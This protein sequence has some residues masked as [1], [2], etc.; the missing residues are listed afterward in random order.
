VLVVVVLPAVLVGLAVAT[1][2]ALSAL[3]EFAHIDYVRRVSDF[4]VPRVGDKIEPETA[5]EAACRKIG[6]RRPAPCGEPVDLDRFDALGYQYEAQQPPLYYAVVAAVRPLVQVGPI[7]SFV[8]AARL[9]GILW[10]VAGLATLWLACRR[11]G[12]SAA[13]AALAVVL[14]QLSPTV[15]S[16]SSTVNNDA[17]LL[18]LGGLCILGF[19]HLR[20]DP[21]LRRGLPLA[22]GAV[23][24][25]LVKPLAVLPVGAA[26]VALVFAAPA[27][28]RRQALVSGAVVAMA[29]GA[30]YVGW[31]LVR[32]RR[33][34][35]PYEV[36][37]EA[38]LGFKRKV[39]SYPIDAVGSSLNEFFHAYDSISA[40]LIDRDYVIGVA[41][42]IALVFV[43]APTLVRALS[44]SD[45]G[46]ARALAVGFLAICLLAPP[47]LV[48]QSYFTVER[49]GGANTRYAIGLLPFALVATA[50]AA[51]R[52]RAFLVCGW[53]ASALLAVATVAGILTA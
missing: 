8:T 52:S 15:L 45:R 31:N 34:T 21:T 29:A 53:A 46:P 48:T 24:L 2:P 13:G 50:E 16:Q 5:Q 7:G 20:R 11:L 10:L 19:D 49:I 42:V 22:A 1:T 9:T 6:G 33:A 35:V 3:D 17:S 40:S 18:L 23:V 43:L 25:V 36:V 47:V 4:E 27:S 32:D 39:D 38:L 28:R 14:V 12:S 30:A 44:I 37:V 51:T 26:T 41:S